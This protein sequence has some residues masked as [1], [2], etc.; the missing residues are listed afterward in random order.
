MDFPK[1][2]H[3]LIRQRLEIPAGK[4]NAVLDS[5]TYNEIDDQ[6]ALVYSLFRNDKINLKAVTAA[7]FFNSRSSSPED[8]MERSYNEIFELLKRLNMN[9]DGKVFRGSRTYLPDYNTPVESPAASALV[10]MALEA[11]QKGEVL[12][13]MAI[14]AITNVA[15]AILMQPEIIKHI[16]VIWLGGNPYYWKTAKEFNL[17][18]D[19]PAAQIIFNSGVPFIHIP[20]INVAQHLIMSI[21]DLE[22][23]IRGRKEIGDY[24]CE[25]SLE[26]MQERNML[27]KVIWDIATPAV[28]TLPKCITSEVVPA[29]IL[30]N[31]MTWTMDPSRHPLRVVTQVNRDGIFKDLYRC[32]DDFAQN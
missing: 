25:F 12:Y 31:D 6:F 1:L 21:P 2:D 13:I 14:G 20:C 27:S 26:Y 15:S 19:V 16:V 22:Y 3:E 24:L 7:P 30:N 5:D 23:Y 4:V 18:Q 28:I 17:M 11:G 32:L 10:N 8:G 9:M 29:P